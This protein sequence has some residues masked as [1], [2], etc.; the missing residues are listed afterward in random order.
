MESASSTLFNL[1]LILVEKKKPG[2]MR[3]DGK[4]RC[5][6]SDLACSHIMRS[7]LDHMRKALSFRL[8]LNYTKRPPEPFTSKTLTRFPWR[9]AASRPLTAD[10]TRTELDCHP[11]NDHFDQT[12]LNVCVGQEAQDGQHGT[13]RVSELLYCGSFRKLDLFSQYT[14]I[15]VGI[16]TWRYT[17]HIIYINSLCF[18]TAARSSHTR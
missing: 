13:S 9:P 8:M 7:I 10:M 18:F 12:A 11:Q 1:Q 2:Q 15:P 6:N 5:K 16:Q 3:R 17:T 4:R 14:Y